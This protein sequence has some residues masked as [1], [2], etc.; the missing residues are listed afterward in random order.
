MPDAYAQHLIEEGIMTNIEV[1]EIAKKQFDAFDKELQLVEQYQPEQSYF[2]KQWEGFVQASK[3]L[4]IW[5]TG[6]PWE[7]LSYVGRNSVYHPADFV[8]IPLKV[9]SN[10]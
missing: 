3:D 4:T 6:L 8:S 9:L 10:F 2:K 7:I 1:E 5:D